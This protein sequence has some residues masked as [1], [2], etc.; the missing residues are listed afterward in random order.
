[1]FKKIIAT[2]GL[3]AIS[4]A[5]N[6]VLAQTSS[7]SS[8]NSSPSSSSNSL[9][10]SSSSASSFSNKAINLVCA[11]TA[12]DTREDALFA[13][14]TTQSNAITTA[15]QTRKSALHE[16]WNIADKTARRN[17][18]KAAWK[19]FNGSMKKSNKDWRSARHAIWIK[20]RKDRQ[21]CRGIS[22]SE[23]VSSEINDRQ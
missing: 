18:I 5:S 16:A 7:S 2:F 1:M 4:A 11:Q 21:S 3:L 17:A 12:V 10:S 9:S 13:A 19:T 6:I 22:A 15:Y 14:R 23:E 20:F 8:S